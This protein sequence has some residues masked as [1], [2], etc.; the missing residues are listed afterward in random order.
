MTARIVPSITS[1]SEPAIGSTSRATRSCRRQSSIAYVGSTDTRSSTRGSRRRH[2]GCTS[3]AR[4]RRGVSG[5]SCASWPGPSS[6]VR[7]SSGAFGA[8]RSARPSPRARSRRLRRELATDNTGRDA[9]EHTDRNSGHG[10]HG[11]HGPEFLEM[12]MPARFEDNQKT[13][14]I[15]PTGAVVVGGDYQGL[16]IVRS[17]GRQGVPVCVVDDECSIARYSRY[18][19]HAIRTS[20]L[21]DE[22]QTVDILLDVGRRLGLQGWVL[23]PTRDE[24]VAAFARYRPLLTEL[25]RVPTP[26]WNTIQWLWDK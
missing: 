9:T 11:I 26:A 15:R 14:G 4:P 25:F 20:S 8:M 1:S 5:R 21:R 18:A 23:Y 24:T 19:T 22:R 6:P 7:R 13:S 10:L 16:G 3:S 17:L 12:L 2:R